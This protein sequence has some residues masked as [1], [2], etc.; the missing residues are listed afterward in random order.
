MRPIFMRQYVLIAN[1]GTDTIPQNR[2]LRKRSSKKENR[3]SSLGFDA[4]EPL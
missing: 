1:G 3:R 4:A 2:Y